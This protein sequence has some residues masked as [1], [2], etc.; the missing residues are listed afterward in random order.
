MKNEQTHPIAMSIA[1]SDPSGGAG[2]QADL[3]VFSARGV[4]GTTVLTALTAQNPEE[5]TAVQGLEDH[6]VKAQAEAVLKLP[7][8]GIKTGMLWSKE[9]VACVALLLD[10]NPQIPTVVDPVMI[11]TSGAKLLTDEAIENYKTMLLP[12]AT[13][14]T[15]N[16]D[17]AEMLL[18]ESIDRSNQEEAARELFDLFGSSVLLKGG[19][20]EGSPID[21]LFDGNKVVRWE[22]DWIDEVNTHGSGCMLSAAICAELAKG[23]GLVESVDLGL[24]FLQKALNN[25]VKIAKSISLANVHV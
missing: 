5:V 25:A 21:I 23:K 3:R 24:N 7:V 9:I 16:I 18:G 12:R 17:E 20:L 19:H 1:G 6:F 11:A 8:R 13:L 2:I 15:P 22:H 10:N 4:Y 14:I